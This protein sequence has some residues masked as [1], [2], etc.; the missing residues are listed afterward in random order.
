MAKTALII[1]A[2]RGLGLGLATE[3][4]GRGWHV[5]ATARDPAAAP[6]LAAAAS[7]HDIIIQTVDIDSPESVAALAA[8]TDGQHYDLL[9]INAGIYGPRHGSADKVTQDDIAALMLTNALAP[10]RLARSFLPR[11]NEGGTIAFMTSV[12]GSVALNTGGTMELYRAS[13]AALN[14]L[15]RSFFAQDVGKRRL[16]VLNLHPG[17]VKTAMGGPDAQIEIAESVGGLADVVIA[18][19]GGGQHYLDYQGNQIPW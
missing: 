16:T 12:L 15:S 8:A 1:G 3:F 11:L 5:T 2:S 13:K 10:I 18:N 14:T 4:A 19:T 6:D 7:S 9:F 17:W